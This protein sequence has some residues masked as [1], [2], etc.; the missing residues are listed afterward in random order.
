MKT[1][2]DFTTNSSSASFVVSKEKLTEEQL[3][4]LLSPEELYNRAI[5][6]YN[7]PCKGKE[8][9]CTCKKIMTCDAYLVCEGVGW[10]IKEDENTNTIYGYTTMDNFDM[11]A[12]LEEELNIQIENY[13]CS[14]SGF[15]AMAWLKENYKIDPFEGE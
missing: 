15:A 4:I 3:K 8:F 5:K 9:S 11:I 12:F 6:R 14:G 1:K 10:A 2:F 13:D 7:P